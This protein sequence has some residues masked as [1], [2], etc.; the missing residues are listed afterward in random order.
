MRTNNIR[1]CSLIRSTVAL[2]SLKEFYEDQRG[3]YQAPTELEMRVYHRLIHI[4]DQRERHEEIPEEIRDHPVF[5]LTTQFRLR[6]QAK[7]APITKTS[8]LVVDNDAMQIFAQ[9]A[10]VLREQNNV[11]MIYLVA[12]IMERLFGKECIEDIESIRGELT[13]PEIIDGISKP[14]E[15]TQTAVNGAVYIESPAE[16]MTDI[17][18]EDP[19]AHE[20]QAI[21]LSQPISKNATEWLASNFG[22]Q[23]QALAAPPPQNGFSSIPIPAP[24][25]TSAFAGLASR[26]APSSFGSESAFSP[27]GSTF[28][29]STSAPPPASAFSGLVTKPSAFGGATFGPT[30]PASTPVFGG[31]SAFKSAFGAGSSTAFGTGASTSSPFPVPPV[32]TSV[33]LPAPAPLT[34][35]PTWPAGPVTSG[36]MS[37]APAKN[38]APLESRAPRGPTTALNPF[39][40]TFVPPQ[41]NS[42]TPSTGLPSAPPPTQPAPTQEKPSVFSTNIFSTPSTVPAPSPAKPSGGIFSVPLFPP[43]QQQTPSTLQPQPSIPPSVPTEPS[44]PVAPEQPLA[45]SSQ[46]PSRIIERRQTLWDL[47]GSSSPFSRLKEERMT[48]TPTPGNAPEPRTPISP[49][50][51][52]PAL[53]RLPHLDLPPTPTARWFDPGSAQ[54]E[55]SDLALSRKRSLLHFPSLTLPTPSASD[56]LSPIHLTTPTPGKNGSAAVGGPSPLFQSHVPEPSPPAASTS[57]S[58]SMPPPPP[59]KA[60]TPPGSRPVLGIQTN[61][62][63]GSAPSPSKESVST[64][65]NGKGKAKETQPDLDAKV[66]KFLRSSAVVRDCWA[67]WR[68]RAEAEHEWEE[69]CKRSEAYKSRVSGSTTSRLGASES[70]REQ[71]KK[72]RI[73]TA[74]EVQ[75]KRAKRRRSKQFEKPL[76]DEALARRLQQVC[77]HRVLGRMW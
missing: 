52:P 32:S 14:L 22:G 38:A 15:D 65:A 39:A 70:G 74:A 69:A 19:Q 40:A 20:R 59:P 34:S 64:S 25:G 28:S 13:I 56:I 77:G 63:A 24:S 71:N 26:P 61:G 62:I 9:L 7:S 35:Q 72:R 2:T 66:A 57:A 41:A 33:S 51:G 10:A 54:D 45:G 46:T 6:V 60:R 36:D 17:E 8:K 68:A 67:R 18:E 31:G 29:S 21:P 44:S 49:T 11:V 23:P 48:F 53:G 76:T 27:S 47:P 16:E 37:T 3:R 4:R 12:C 42:F 1:I 58:T 43:Q 5:N 50:A 73:S 75:E 30:T 55:A